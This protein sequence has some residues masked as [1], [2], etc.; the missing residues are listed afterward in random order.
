M[1]QLVVLQEVK[2]RVQQYVLLPP[3]FSASAAILKKIS[4]RTPITDIDTGESSLPL[5]DVIDLVDPDKG[6][7]VFFW[8]A[9]KFIRVTTSE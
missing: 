2:G 7:I 4:R 1:D 9:G 6:E 5:H 3:Q 8:K